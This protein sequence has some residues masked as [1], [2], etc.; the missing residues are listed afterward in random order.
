MRRPAYVKHWVP[1]IM[2]LLLDGNPLGTD[3]FASHRL[4]LDAG[5]EAYEKFQRKGDG[6]V[7][8]LLRPLPRADGIEARA[9]RPRLE[10]PGGDDRVF[11]QVRVAVLEVGD[12][13]HVLRE[14]P[15]YREGLRERVDEEVAEVEIRPDD[16]VRVV[17]LSRDQAPAGRESQTG[18]DRHPREERR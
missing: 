15:R 6:Y 5:R 11:D 12:D 17:E 9:S 10:L 4:P 18:S 7:K 13:R 16:D 14:T 2:P 1:E 8:V 3:S